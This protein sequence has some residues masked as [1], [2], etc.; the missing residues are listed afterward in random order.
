MKVPALPDDE[1]ERL[2]ALRRYAVL[3]TP[4]EP[5]FDA[6][7]RV[8]AHVLGVPIALVSL[9]DS[10]RQWF[11]SHHGTDLT[12]T[13]RDI[14]FCGHVVSEDAPLVVRDA[15]R[16]ERFMDNP[17]VTGPVGIRFYA[18]FPLRT[19]DG[20]VLGSL[21]AIDTR[22]H[23]PA[24]ADLDLLD[25]LAR[26]TV[27]QLELRY[28]A[29]LLGEQGLRFR[30]VLQTATDAI[31][32][33]D[34][35]GWIEQVNPAAERMFG[36]SSA[37]LLGQNI[38]LLMPPEMRKAHDRGMA[39]YLAT[40]HRKVVGIGRELVAQRRDGSTFPID[41]MVSEM[42]LGERRLFTGFLRDAT[43]RKH[44][45]QLLEETLAGLRASHDNMLQLLNSIEIGV[46]LIDADRSIAFANSAF[47][48]LCAVAAERVLGRAWTDVLDIDETARQAIRATRKLP[49]AER[50][51][52]TIRLGT[53]ERQPRWVEMDVRDN[54]NNSEQQILFL[55]DVT[56]LHQLKDKLVLSQN[57]QLIGESPAMLAVFDQIEQ[58]AQG[59]WTVLIEG[60]TGVGKELVARA[61]H[62][63]SARHDR[64]FVAVNCAG[65]TDSILGSQLFGH[66]RGAFTGADADRPGVF[67]AAQG[68]TLFLDEIGD[69]SSTVQAA[70]LRVLQEKEITRL[71]ETRSRKVDVRIIL[72]TH[73][74][75][76]GLVAKGQ[77]RDDLLYRIHS[78][79]IRVPPLRERLQDVPELAASFLA[80]QRTVSGKLVLGFEPRV[81][82]RLMRYHWP[83]NIREL[84]STI[85]YA[86]VRSRGRHIGLADLPVEIVEATQSPGGPLP[87]VNDERTQILAAL[88]ATGGNRARAARLLGIGRATL[89]RHLAELGIPA[90][91][92]ES[93]E[94]ES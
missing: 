74:D 36:Y 2:A 87:E 65:L 6:L 32:A 81:L 35:G 52:L 66:V 94:T 5:E 50:N 73:R 53:T 41:A 59:D 44:A 55:Y 46:L 85:E 13:A 21:C 7:T 91:G 75:L 88:R 40:G 34:E 4:A 51:R 45:E 43:Q 78:A 90:K 72:A 12:E 47:C 15:S 37:E 17:L 39:D 8:A 38:R 62:N 56:D 11:K 30:S 3:D 18:G 29:H 14:S 82:D 27:D 25:L 48:A 49:A 23:E 80:Q 71:G 22:P 57:D 79:R 68:G 60:E 83:G 86:L 24:A 19:S 92:E 26:Q 20:F 28:K 42:F 89:Y 10:E 64:E 31:I 58:L 69:I 77:F 1:Q 16:D 70:L 63:A 33:I 61:I 93:A 84:R 67:E 9:V 76:P 54:P